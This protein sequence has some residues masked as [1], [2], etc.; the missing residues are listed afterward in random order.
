MSLSAFAFAVLLLLLTPGP[1]NTLLAVSGATRGLMASLPLIGAECAGY[2][3]AIVPL[4][5]LAAPLLIDQPAAALGIKLASTLWVLLLAA[6]LWMRPP[7]ANAQGGT[8]VA[9]VYATTVLNP[10]ALIIGLALI[11]A[12]GTASLEAL[13][14]PLPYLAV[15]SLLVV[16][17]ATCWLSAGAAILQRLATTNP[18]LF[19]RVAASCLVAFALS[20]AG[21]AIGWI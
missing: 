12:A 18:L 13:L 6:R 1:T 8:T 14:R 3:T 16:I 9:A 10:K 5:F 21:R 11:P 20:L 4:V 7:S 2:L 17:V 19:G 15:F